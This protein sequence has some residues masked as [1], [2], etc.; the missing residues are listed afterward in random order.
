LRR[1]WRMS[2]RE[3]S[4]PRGL[5]RVTGSKSAGIG[6]KRIWRPR[7][8]YFD[9]APSLPPLHKFAQNL[10]PLLAAAARHQ[11]S[12]LPQQARLRS[13]DLAARRGSRSCLLQGCLQFAQFG[14]AA[15]RPFPELGCFLLKIILA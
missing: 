6:N 4:S 15:L 8:I 3:T 5:V 7:P 10:L 11:K 14:I 1:R 2:R 12:R 13:T 9:A